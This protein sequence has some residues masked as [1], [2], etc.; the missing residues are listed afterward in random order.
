MLHHAHI[1]ICACLMSGLNA[2]T[3]LM[4]LVSVNYHTLQRDK[5][6]ISLAFF[7]RDFILSCAEYTQVRD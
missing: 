6:T 7:W 2:S 5:L 4:N 1:N 3:I